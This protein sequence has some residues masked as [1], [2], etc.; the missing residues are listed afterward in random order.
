MLRILT[1]HRID[2]HREDAVLSPRMVSAEP[3]AFDAQ[4]RWV[5]QHYETV[6]L[7]D[8]VQSLHGGRRLPSRAVLVTFDDAYRDFRTQAWPIL[9]ARRIPALLFVPTAFPDQQNFHFWWDRLFRAF[10]RTTAP[11]LEHTPLGSLPTDGPEHRAKSQRRLETCL[12][13]MSHESAM[14]WVEHV[15]SEAGVPDPLD[16][17]VLNWDELRA[18]SR[19]GVALASHAHEHPLLTRVTPDRAREEMVRSRGALIREIGICPPA[20]SYPSGAHDARVAALVREAGFE[21]GFTQRDGHNDLKTHDLLALCRTNITRK[22]TPMI[23]ELRL[24]PWMPRIDRWRHRSR[25]SS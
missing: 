9:A 5:A 18:L 4:M 15:C 22:T 20:L 25:A 12:K 11:A 8:V 2:A 21:L 3:E 7:A 19:A 24:Q 1:Y 14:R 16:N 6:A 17:G 13:L 10:Q 23:L